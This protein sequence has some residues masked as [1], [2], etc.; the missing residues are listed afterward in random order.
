M[1]DFGGGAVVAGFIHGEVSWASDPDRVASH[2]RTMCTAVAHYPWTATSLDTA[3][4]ASAC[5]ALA[6]QRA[7]GRSTLPAASSATDA[8]LD[9]QSALWIAADLQLHARADLT[10]Q[11]DLAAA[12]AALLSD[13]ALV[14]AAY[15]RWG[16]GCAERLVGEGAFA[17]WDAM[18]ERLFCWRDPGGVRPF[19]Y[20]HVPGRGLVF[21]SDLQA[22]VAHPEVPATLDL[23]YTRAYLQRELF[24]HPTRTF[25]PAVTKLPAAHLLVLDRRGLSIQRYWDPESISEQPHID[26]HEGAEELR[27][28]VRQAID[29]RIATT[30]RDTVGAHLSG[31]LDSSS[32]TLL[33]AAHIAERG[34]Q[35]NAFSWSPA[36]GMVEPS[37]QDER[38]LVEAVTDFGGIRTHYAQILPSDIADAC[39]RDI[40]LRP[41]VTLNYEMA[42]SRQAVATGVHTLLSGWGGD[43]AIAFNG[44]GYFAELARGA[45]FATIHRELKLRQ[46][47][48]GGTLRGAWKH[49]VLWPH[50]PDWLVRRPGP[51]DAAELPSYFRP[52]FARLLSAV[53]PL[54]V[55]ALRERPGVHRMQTTLLRFGHLPARAES[56]TAHG[57]SL[58]LT[59]TFPLL[60]RRILDFALSL[61]GR[62]FFRDGWKRWLYRTAMAGVLPDRIRW[63]PSK[64]DNAASAQ[65][66]AVLREP[67]P[68]YREP[69]LARVDNPLIDIDGLLA[70]TDQQTTSQIGLGSWF[71]FTDL[72]PA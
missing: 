39:Y 18:A 36:R 26:D 12:E 57:A 58:G 37:E 42:T 40:A 5:C 72:L 65:M 63:N 1:V 7:P 54:E 33:A 9:P 10:V 68:A 31:G 20:H 51:Q 47:I 4:S 53:D 44:R 56:W 62:M 46:R 71:A 59:Y 14:L 66:K 19:Y 52:E 15:R 28:L 67:S 43:E 13:E 24:Q 50:L 3:E 69:L 29:D 49:R 61:P 11:L 21:S 60:D 16:I 23:A 22:I 30:D 34:D 41:A 55:D 64:Y 6:V 38:D 17:V 45:H 2:V 48:Q 35:F 70:V 8:A 25:V 32:I 27:T